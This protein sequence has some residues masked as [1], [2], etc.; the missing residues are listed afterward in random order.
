MNF[1][2][3]IINDALLDTKKNVSES[4]LYELNGE[5]RFSCSEERK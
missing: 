5:N 4:E 2:I 3:G 1:F